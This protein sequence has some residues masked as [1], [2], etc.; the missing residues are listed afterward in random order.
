LCL[1]LSFDASR[2]VSLQ[3]IKV[4][5]CVRSN[6]GARPRP[7]KLFYPSPIFPKQLQTFKKLFVLFLSPPSLILTSS[8]YLCRVLGHL[9]WWLILIFLPF[10]ALFS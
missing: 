8:W 7:Y 4:L 6:L 5:L 9:K 3:S 10:I 1:I 2:N